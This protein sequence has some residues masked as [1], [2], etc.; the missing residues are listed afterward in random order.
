[1]L[2]LKKRFPVLISTVF[3]A[4]V[5]NVSS[6]MVAKH[7]EAAS[8]RCQ[9]FTC[10]GLDSHS[11]VNGTRI[12]CYAGSKVL[13]TYPI[14]SLGFMEIRYSTGCNSQWTEVGLTNGSR[15]CDT[16]IGPR[17]C[18]NPAIVYRPRQYVNGV[19]YPSRNYSNASGSRA[20][21]AR[22]YSAMVGARYAKANHTGCI[23]K[24]ISLYCYGPMQK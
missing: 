9:D 1:M 8:Y 7:L 16:R 19:L 15:T 21:S 5:F 2:R 23:S 12:S 10:D 20:G 14:S 3:L 18:L 13:G 4:S 11:T 24:D 22:Q 17:P 6:T